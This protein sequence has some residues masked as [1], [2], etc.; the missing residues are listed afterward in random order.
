MN[1]SFL[2]S[3]EWGEFQKSFGRP[4]WLLDSKIDA[5]VIKHKLPF[6]KNYLY[7][8]Y[9]PTISFEDI[10]GGLRDEVNSF[11]QQLRE[12]AKKE[13][14][15]F[16]KL[17]PQSDVVMELLYRRG[18]KRSNKNIQPSKTVVIDLKKPE[19]E[20]SAGMHHKTRYNINL[21]LKKNMEFG[22]S[23]VK[24]SGDDHVAN[25][26]VEL[27]W[28]LLKQTS[29]EDKFYTH[30]KEYYKKL[31]NF[32]DSKLG[33][34]IKTK[35]VF[36]YYEGKPIASAILLI[37]DNTVYYLHGAM[38]REHKQL[39]A[40]YKMHWEIIM[41]AKSKGYEFYDL[42][43]VDANKW[44][45]VTRFKFGWGGRTIEYP[46]SFDMPVSSFWYLA[47]RLVSKIR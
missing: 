18:F 30:E 41:W 16:V 22:E 23:H 36:V 8:P 46:G 15:I 4:V 25:D 7:I 34:S 21:A 27:F 11:I 2:Q 13:K 38:D 28:K 31:L 44:P 33:K 12:L 37:Y 40:P 42:W 1:K 45:G 24:S 35:L 5:L 39:M 17:E 3:A 26:D 14:S 10:R 47:Y 9:G 32:F 19:V 6:G 29:K 20:L 43:G